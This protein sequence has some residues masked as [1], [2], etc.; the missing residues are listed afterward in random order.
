MANEELTAY[1]AEELTNKRQRLER[2]EAVLEKAPRYSV[3]LK[4]IQGRQYYYKKYREKGKVKTDYL[5]P[6]SKDVRKLQEDSERLKEL[7]KEAR[8][9]RREVRI[10]EKQLA[11]ARKL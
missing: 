6:A 1:L 9:L 3:Q 4:T 5:G 8:D 11:L 10:M 7:S 2:V